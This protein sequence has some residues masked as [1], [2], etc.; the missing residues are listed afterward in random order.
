MDRAK[1]MVLVP[2]KHTTTHSVGKDVNKSIAL[3]GERQRENVDHSIVGPLTNKLLSLDDAM[4][5][6]LKDDK[7][8]DMEKMKKYTSTMQTYMEYRKKYS[9]P[10]QTAPA[11]TMGGEEGETPQ[12]MTTTIGDSSATLSTI[13]PE[14][15]VHTDITNSEKEY[16]EKDEPTISNI[17]GI[18]DK[19]QDKPKTVKNISKYDFQKRWLVWFHDK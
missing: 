5:K 10:T 6:I 1:K 3:L 12:S 13:I 16:T 14:D 17:P 4:E 18:E 9:G 7:L 2:Y 8:S 19:S 15:V 11:G